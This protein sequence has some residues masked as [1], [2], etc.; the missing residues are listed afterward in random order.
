MKWGRDRWRW[1]LRRSSISSRR[2]RSAFHRFFPSS[3]PRMRSGL[4]SVTS[5]VTLLEVLVVP[6]RAGNLPL[7]NRYE[8]L[9]NRSRG[10]RLREINRALLRAAAQL[11]ATTGVRTPDALQLAAALAEGCTAFVTND[12]RLPSLPRLR[13]L[14]V[15]DHTLAT[16][17]VTRARRF[18][19]SIPV[20]GRVECRPYNRL[21]WMRGHSCFSPDNKSCAQPSR[22]DRWRAL[23]EAQRSPYRSPLQSRPNRSRV[24][25][26]QP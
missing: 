10:V 15:G 1:T 5:A 21:Q 9:L 18:E 19:T 25:R 3:L 8:A 14:R 16:G 13:I 22:T 24:Q 20:P 7:A 2:T 6:Y 12:R 17:G 11:R 23:A 26:S 4:T